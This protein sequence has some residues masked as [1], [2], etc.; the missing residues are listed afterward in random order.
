MR[1]CNRCRRDEGQVNL[2]NYVFGP[3]LCATSDETGFVVKDAQRADLCDECSRAVN[4]AVPHL[5]TMPTP[6]QPAYSLPP[7]SKGALR[8]L[9]LMIVT[10]TTFM[11][12]VA[13]TV[14]WIV[15]VA[16]VLQR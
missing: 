8:V 1:I 6:G 10:F 13:A 9:G 11:L 4:E 3:V 12:T 7:E 2:R 16:R 5:L 15:F 14:A